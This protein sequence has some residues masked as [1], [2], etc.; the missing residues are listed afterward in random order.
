MARGWRWARISR[1][2]RWIR[3]SACT[4]RSR[5]PTPT[6]SRPA[7]VSVS[8]LEKLI[9]EILETE[10]DLADGPLTVLRIAALDLRDAELARE[11]LVNR[12]RVLRLPY[13]AQVSRGRTDLRRGHL[14]Q[15]RR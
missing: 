11:E 6:E 9:F 10:A 15:K 5:A 7:A 14:E 4:Q 1:W 3:G 12:V 13:A 8:D 2:S